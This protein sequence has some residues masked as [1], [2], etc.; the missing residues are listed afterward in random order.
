MLRYLF[1]TRIFLIKVRSQKPQIIITLKTGVV[2]PKLRLPVVSFQTYAYK[3]L[4]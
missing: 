4:F 1:V 3:I 2:K